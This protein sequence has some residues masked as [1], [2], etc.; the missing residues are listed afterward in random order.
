MHEIF[1]M[2]DQSGYFKV[3]KLSE[4]VR[5]PATE[6]LNTPLQFQGVATPKTISLAGY[7]HVQ[8]YSCVCKF[9][10]YQT[11]KGFA[12]YILLRAKAYQFS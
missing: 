6:H 3:N 7:L 11:M 5:G 1:F 2:K 12:F 8:K 9:N 10:A 4:M